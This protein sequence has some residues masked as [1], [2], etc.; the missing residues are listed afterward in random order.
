[1]TMLPSQLS[2]TLDMLDRGQLKA[3]VDM[4]LPSEM[5]GTL[6]QVSG[7]LALALISAGLF[8]G[9]SIICT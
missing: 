2:N 5:T 4:K 9:S 6:Y 8:V 7:H 1:M 3:A